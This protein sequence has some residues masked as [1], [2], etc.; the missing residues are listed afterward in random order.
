[1]C[2]SG[3]TKTCKYHFTNYHKEKE[4]LIVMKIIGQVDTLQQKDHI[5]YSHKR[6]VLFPKLERNEVHWLV[7]L[8]VSH[9]LLCWRQWYSYDIMYRLHQHYDSY[10]CVTRVIIRRYPCWQHFLYQFNET[11]R[12]LLFILWDVSMLILWTEIN[13]YT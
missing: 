7:K 8:S 9:D 12:K 1:M 13:H 6:S 4:K 3:V 10:H 2:G 5:R 11:H